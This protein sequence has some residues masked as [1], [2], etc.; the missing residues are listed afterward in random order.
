M[1]EKLLGADDPDV[2]QWLNN[3]ANLLLNTRRYAEAEPLYRRAIEIGTRTLGRDHSRVATRLN[4]LAVVLMD[5]G[6]YSEAEELLLEA[7][8]IVEQRSGRE[9]AIFATR[10]YKFANLLARTDRLEEAETAFRETIRTGELKLG[11]D[12][13]RVADWKSGLAKVLRDSGRWS[14]AEPLFREGIE[15]WMKT[16]D[17]AHTS[18]GFLRFEFSKLLLAVGRADEACAEATQALAIHETAFGPTHQWTQDSAAALAAALDVLGRGEEAAAARQRYRL[19][20]SGDGG[21]SAG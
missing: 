17:H 21:S 12:N 8:Q 16:G 9:S 1:G 15:A 20:A 3:F 5:T 14:E 13:R 11:R 19:T 7:M 18:V 2:G 4:N 10:L 6:R